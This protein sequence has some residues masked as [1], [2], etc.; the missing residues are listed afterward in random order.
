MN[1]VAPVE[2]KLCFS[3]VEHDK[4]S[5]LLEASAHYRMMVLQEAREVV[6]RS[7]VMI[8]RPS[9]CAAISPWV[10]QDL[11]LAER[12]LKEWKAC[13]EEMQSE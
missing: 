5:G 12:H 1:V 2:A 7:L 6:T 3:T 8:E 10:L 4:L 11:S 9:V 13:V